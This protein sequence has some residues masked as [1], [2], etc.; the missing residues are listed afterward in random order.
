MKTFSDLEKLL[1]RV[2][3]ARQETKAVIAKLEASK[4]DHSEEAIKSLVNPKIKQAKDNLAAIHQEAF[5]KAI[6]ILQDLGKDAMEKS[7]VLNLN[8]PALANALKLIE[9]SGAGISTETVRKIN[10]RFAGDQAALRALRDIY[11]AHGVVYDGGL[12]KQIYE[13]E[14]A[15][16]HL[17][18]WAYHSFTKEGSLN[19]FASAIN[20][21]ASME[22]IEFPK[23]V[24]EVGSDEVMRSAAGL[25]AK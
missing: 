12:D 14:S 19:E 21:V 23:M 24:D 11:K 18:E 25:S 7:S 22:G 2:A 1:K 10:S 16:D 4:K 5:E 15:F 3:Q 9:L 20:K 6:E 13:P 8:N 17:G